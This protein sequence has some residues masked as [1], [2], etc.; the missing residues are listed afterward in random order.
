MD[1]TWFQMEDLRRRKLSGS[2]WIPLRSS[3]TTDEVGRI[4]HL[5]YSSEFYGVG[6]VAVYTEHRTSA[7]E[8]GWHDIGIRQNHFGYVENGAYVPADAYEN[9]RRTVHGLH[10]VLDQDGEGVH[11]SIWHL[12][13]DVVVTLGLRRQGDVWTRPREGYI[14]VVRLRKQVD[15]TPRLLEIRA[16]HMRDYL[17]ARGMALYV[18]S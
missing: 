18:T 3:M 9:H 15:G 7:G 12:H 6:S 10:L 17:C 5:G 1:Q 16:S 14:D 8:L 4:G 2:V 11:P 13:Q